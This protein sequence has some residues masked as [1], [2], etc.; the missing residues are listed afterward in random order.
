VCWAW[1][2]Q[3]ISNKTIETRRIH[4]TSRAIRTGRHERVD[5]TSSIPEMFR[6]ERCRTEPMAEAAA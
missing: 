4:E 6:D 2:V 5:S 3:I 1:P